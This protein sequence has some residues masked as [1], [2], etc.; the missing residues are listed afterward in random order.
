MVCVMMSEMLG[1]SVE[2]VWHLERINTEEQQ[3][4]GLGTLEQLV[5][6]V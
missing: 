6:A 2:I 5:T 4:K 1:V 3:G